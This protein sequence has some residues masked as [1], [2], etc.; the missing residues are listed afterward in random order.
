MLLKKAE[1]HVHLEGTLSP[2]LAR[3]IAQR[4]KLIFPEKVLDLDR[5]SYTFKDFLDFLKVYDEV[6]A[7]IKYPK[8]YYDLTFD[9]L[10]HRAEENV[11]YVEMMYS[12]DHAE[13]SS[14][15]L[16]SE[17]LHAIQE[18]INDAEAQF[19]IVGRIIITAVRHFGA[20]SAIKVATQALKEQVPCIVGF[21]LGGDEINYPPR[22]F[23]KAYKIA[24]EGGLFCTVHAGE[25]SPASGMQEAMH[26]LPIQRIGHGVQAIHSPETIAELKDKQIALEICPSSNIALKLFKD[27]QSHPLPE[28]LKEGLQI[29]L[30]SDDPPF[31]RTTLGAE[32]ERVQNA[33]RYSNEEMLNFTNMAIESSFADQRTKAKLR[34]LMETA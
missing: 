9:Y 5:K 29:S 14:G 20:E 11:I 2:T 24:A 23:T 19:N 15:L 1:L 4:N 34:T 18:A 10:K 30:N 32:Y 25:F 13:Q 33:Y 27:F 6:A 16:S 28:L 17:H 22:L 31:F 8:D 3:K 21:G 7:L 26:Y 12:P